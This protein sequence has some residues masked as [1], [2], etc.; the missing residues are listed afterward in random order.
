MIT[1]HSLRT[2]PPHTRRRRRIA[3]GLVAVAAAWA[4]Y[5]LWQNIMPRIQVGDRAPDFTAIAQDGRQIRLAD[6]VGKQTVVV[7][8][9]PKDN[10]PGCTV[11]ACS[12]RDAYEEFVAAGAVVIGVSSDSAESHCG[13][14][15]KHHL[16]FVLVSDQDQSLRKTFGVPKTLAFIPGRVTYVIDRE[17]VVRHIFNSQ[18]NAPR[19]VAESLEIVRQLSP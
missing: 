19:H 1:E 6:Y 2:A 14:A 18:F 12:F 7:Y 3:L 5:Y 11:Q 10:T 15:E 16:P 8:F 13:F 9:Y 17:G 4:S